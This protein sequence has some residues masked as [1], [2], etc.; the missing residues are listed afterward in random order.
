MRDYCVRI[1]KNCHKLYTGSIDKACPVCNWKTGPSV[2]VNF[3]GSNDIDDL[4]VP[5]IKKFLDKGYHTNGCCSSHLKTFDD[6]LSINGK[7]YISFEPFKVDI[8]QLD[9]PDAED[10]AALRE[11]ADNLLSQLKNHK[12]HFITRGEDSI[13]SKLFLAYESGKGA[14]L[15]LSNYTLLNYDWN[16]DLMYDIFRYNE[17]DWY[18]GCS[19][20][21]TIDRFV[22]DVVRIKEFNIYK[23][24]A[25]LCNILSLIEKDID[26][27]LITRSKAGDIA[28][29]GDIIG[30]N[31]IIMTC[32][33]L[34]PG[35]TVNVYN[36]GLSKV[37]D[38][39]IE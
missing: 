3:K 33:S 35:S 8:E 4:M 28:M 1:C 32:F 25:D 34:E 36:M 22:I 6:F 27:Y 21:I 12:P 17:A 37:Q 20:K 9:F 2:N 10:K 23:Y 18:L 26:N 13:L 39:I 30:D 38:I 15:K 19:I 16:I 7:P 31:N 29:Y 24:Y 11:Y 5:L 14:T